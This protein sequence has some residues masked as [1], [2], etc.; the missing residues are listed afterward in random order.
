MLARR[1]VLSITG[2]EHIRATN[3]PFVLVLNHSTRTE[4]L[5]VPALLVFHRDGRLIHFLADWN[6]R[7]IPGIGLIY[8]RAETVS[9]MRKP[10]RPRILNVL[11]P[12]Y[13]PRLTAFEQARRH[14]TAGRSVGLFPE[15][16]VNR[17]P[18]QLLTGRRGAARL[19]LETGTPVIPVGIRFPDVPPGHR[20]GDGAAMAVTIGEPLPPP[21]PAYASGRRASLADVQAW[22]AAIMAEIGRLCGKSWRPHPPFIHHHE[23]AADERRSRNR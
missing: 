17:C 20:I 8:R 5:L 3:D 11:K 9:V 19:S 2:L 18:L 16:T 4:V 15:G 7:L 23:E 14:L 6:F 10:A 21:A 13:R 22:H 12:L 1:Q